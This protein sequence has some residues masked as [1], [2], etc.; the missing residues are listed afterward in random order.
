MPGVPMS[1]EHVECSRNPNYA[2]LGFGV[3]CGV[4][5]QERAARS[6]RPGACGQQ[7]AARSVR[8]AA[9]GQQHAASSVRPG[10]CGQERA[11]R[12]VW[13]RVCACEMCGQLTHSP[14]SKTGDEEKS[15]G[16]F[17]S[18]DSFLTAS[19]GFLG[20]FF[21]ILLTNSCTPCAYS[22]HIHRSI[23]QDRITT[24]KVL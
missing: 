5:G 2:I 14:E 15:L 8:P 3:V 12:S 11:A 22:V 18:V 19:F 13:P 4:C 7:R 16:V 20:Q 1:V 21:N 24:T 9:C 23:T 17:K 10:A 6:V